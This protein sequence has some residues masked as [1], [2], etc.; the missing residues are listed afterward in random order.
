[1]LL[2]WR[3]RLYCRADADCVAGVSKKMRTASVLADLDDISLAVWFADDGTRLPNRKAKAGLAL[4]AGGC[5]VNDAVLVVDRLTEMGLTAKLHKN[6]RACHTLYFSTEAAC[7]LRARIERY[8]PVC[9]RYKFQDV[10]ESG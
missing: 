5:T 4:Y 1:M 7:V 6:S 2:A 8:L 10:G 9:M 3:K